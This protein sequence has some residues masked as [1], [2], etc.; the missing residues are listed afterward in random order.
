MT[1]QPRPYQTEA[2]S[3]W[4]HT[5]QPHRYI[6]AHSPG[7]GKSFTSLLCMRDAYVERLL[8]VC[9]ALVRENWK[10]EVLR[11]LNYD[12]GVIRWGRHRKLSKKEAAI[13]EHEYKAQIVIVSY[14]L[15]GDVDANWDGIILDEA[16]CLR[17]PL[18][19]QSKTV[20]ALLLHNVDAHAIALS[21]TLIPKEAKQI[22]GLVDSLVPG[23]FGKRSRVGD[24]GYNF[25]NKYC[26]KTVNAYG[27]IFHGLKES[28]APALEQ[29]LLGVCHR[30][31]GQDFAQYLPPLFVQPLHTDSDRLADI[32]FAA[33]WV[34][35][36][37][38]DTPHIGIYTH[39]RQT[40]YDIADHLSRAHKNV[41][42][43]TGQDSAKQRDDYLECAKDAESSI[44]V[45]TTHAL[46]QGLSLSFQKAALIVEW[47]TSPAEVIQFIGRFARQ[48]SVSNAPTNVEFIVGPNDVGRSERLVQRISDINKLLAPGTAEEHAQTVFQTVEQSEDEF[49][50]SVAQLIDGVA[51][52][53]I[54]WGADDDDEDDGQHGD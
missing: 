44:I 12:P 3:K 25:L 35:H 27:T 8:I 11:T 34:A 9:P 7:A 54:L 17:N 49:E 30:V 19:Q 33:Q 40:A 36:R 13:R 52:R 46:N 41:I 39:L 14:D 5:P 1:R 20:R 29:K 6:L 15:L 23:Y 26:N 38:A 18:S 45:G 48:D 53:A 4:L 37:I 31:T 16:H 50:A 28:A 21:G 51:K 24:V 22:F 32:D 10:R 2:I 42:T 43:I 47:T